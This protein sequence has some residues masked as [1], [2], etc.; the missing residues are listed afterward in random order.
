[1]GIPLNDIIY[2]MCREVRVKNWDL[3]VEEK[4]EKVLKL[5]EHILNILNTFF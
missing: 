4:G 3:R 5:S 2:F 1:M